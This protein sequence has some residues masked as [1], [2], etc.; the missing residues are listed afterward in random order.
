MASSFYVY[1]RVAPDAEAAARG[2]VMSLL[3]RVR[4]QSGVHG[5]LL[6]KRGE[7]QLW[8]EVYENVHDDARFESILG[9]GVRELALDKVLQHGSSRRVECFEDF[10]PCA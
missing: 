1:Y 3:E 10:N 7:T 5:R 8:M 9:A 4:S 2:R 6:R